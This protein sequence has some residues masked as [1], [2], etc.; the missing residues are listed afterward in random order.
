M[1]SKIESQIKKNDKIQNKE[2]DEN[3]IKEKEK[4]VIT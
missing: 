3:K 2:I 4:L 1:P